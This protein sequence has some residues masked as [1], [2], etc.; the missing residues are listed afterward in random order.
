MIFVQEKVNA[1]LAS[2]VAAGG[3]M[4]VVGTS[5]GLVLGFDSSQTLRW[6]DQEARHQGS[7]SALCFNHDGSRILAGFARGHILMID[8]SNGK[9]LRTLT[10]VHPLDTAVLHV[11]VR[12]ACTILVFN[13]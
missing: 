11:K 13:M 1:G 5:H 2:A 9:V 12:S 4:L 8:S 6:C 7:V 3:N 10:D